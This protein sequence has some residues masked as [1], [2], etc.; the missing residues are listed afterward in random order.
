MINNDGNLMDAIFIGSMITLLHFRRPSIE[1]MAEDN[2]KIF[3][4]SEKKF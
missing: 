2:I 4:E 1:I 3:K